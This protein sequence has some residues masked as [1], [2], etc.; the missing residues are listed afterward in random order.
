LRELVAMMRVSAH[1][2]PLLI[3]KTS[4]TWVTMTGENRDEKAR[5]QWNGRNGEIG[6]EPSYASLLTR[7]SGFP[8]AGSRGYEE[9]VRTNERIARI[10][11]PSPVIPR[12]AGGDA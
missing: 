8:D 4:W 9:F 12:S 5:A 2:P 1:S 10:L 3:P 11:D 6:Y 7:G